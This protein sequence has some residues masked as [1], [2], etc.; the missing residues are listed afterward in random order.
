MHLFEKYLVQIY[1]THE[2]RRCTSIDK[3]V[4]MHPG[5]LYVRLTPLHQN[6]NASH[7]IFSHI[8]N[9]SF[10]IKQYHKQKVKN[11]LKLNYNITK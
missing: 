9:Q 1:R 7:L 6:I 4:W 8:I 5:I 3:V 2:N 11:S 10:I